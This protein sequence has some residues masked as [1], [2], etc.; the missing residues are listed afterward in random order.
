M[1]GKPLE[2]GEPQESTPYIHLIVG[3]PFEPCVARWGV[4]MTD[5]SD[6]QKKCMV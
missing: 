5:F 6:V 3:I 2:M 1:V 4:E